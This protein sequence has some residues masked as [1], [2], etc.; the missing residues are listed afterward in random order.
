MISQAQ[1]PGLLHE[2]LQKQRAGELA[3]A[4]RLYR[5]ILAADGQSA[6]AWN[7]LAAVS[8]ARDRLD[9]AAEAAQRATELRPKIAP[10]WLMRGGIEAARGRAREAQSAYRRAIALEPDFAEAHYGLGRS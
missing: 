3:E 5:E 4:E 10:Y 7:M 8:R 1:I 6:D 9:E 2:A